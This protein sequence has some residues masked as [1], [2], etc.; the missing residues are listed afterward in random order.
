MIFES[1]WRR[2]VKEDFMIEFLDG[3]NSISD[4]KKACR[5]S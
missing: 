1:K 3:I 5:L 4:H 2:N